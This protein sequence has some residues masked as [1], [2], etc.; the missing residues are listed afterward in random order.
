M[1]WVHVHYWHWLVLIPTC[2]RSCWFCTHRNIEDHGLPTRFISPTQLPHLYYF[3]THIL[4]L[5]FVRKSRI[6]IFLVKVGILVLTSLDLEKKGLNLMYSVLLWKK[7]VHCGWKV[8]V[9]PQKRGFILDWKVSVLSW[10][11]SH[12]E[13]RSQC[14]A[15]KKG[16]IFKLENKDGYHF[17]QWVR[18][19]GS[20]HMTIV[21][22]YD[23]MV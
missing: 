3:K 11:G 13:L 8:S 15:T 18:E 7:G 17:F 6:R 10:K 23:R 19:P 2:V 20:P 9:L 4:V 12:F 16:V 14:F 1:F 5:K 21:Y 22:G